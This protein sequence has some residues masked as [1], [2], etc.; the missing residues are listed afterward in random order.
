MA[1]GLRAMGDRADGEAGDPEFG[2]C[3]RELLALGNWLRAHAVSHL[4]MLSGKTR[5]GV[6]FGQEVLERPP[7][8]GDP[9]TAPTALTP[10]HLEGAR[11]A[12][13][14]ADGNGGI[15]VAHRAMRR[16]TLAAQ[17]SGGNRNTCSG[18]GSHLK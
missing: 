16:V 2:R 9:A 8:D 12:A 6:Q 14:T 15:L 13:A 10:S 4:L 11:G 7:V 1:G 3:T 17:Y 5:R 18:R